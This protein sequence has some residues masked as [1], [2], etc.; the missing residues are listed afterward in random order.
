MMY[1]I[2][3]NNSSSCCL[4]FF[5]VSCDQFTSISHVLATGAITYP[6]PEYMYFYF[7]REQTEAVT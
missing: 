1:S 5:V 3:F 2:I 7:I 4:G 6:S